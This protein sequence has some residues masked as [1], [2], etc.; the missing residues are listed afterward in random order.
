MR[1]GPPRSV[2][3][4]ARRRG[5]PAPSTRNPGLEE[6]SVLRAALTFRFPD[7]P[8]MAEKIRKSSGV[9]LTQV[10]LVACNGALGLTLREALHAL[11][12]TPHGTTKSLTL[13]SREQLDGDRSEASHRCQGDGRVCFED[14]T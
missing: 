2:A 3:A 14:T 6:E 1:T 8:S 5:A 12:A 7:V 11:R 9:L 10:K 4:I 13:G